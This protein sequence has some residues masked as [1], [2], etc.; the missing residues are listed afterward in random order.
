M[1]RA[2]LHALSCNLCHPVLF[3]PLPYNLAQILFSKNNSPYSSHS[4]CS[5]NC[6]HG[7]PYWGT[8]M[9]LTFLFFIRKFSEMSFQLHL[10]NSVHQTI[11]TLQGSVQ[12]SLHPQSLHNTPFEN[13]IFIH[14]SILTSTHY[15][16]IS[17]SFFFIDVSIYIHTY[18]YVLSMIP[19][20]ISY[21]LTNSN[22]SINIWWVDNS[23]RLFIMNSYT[24]VWF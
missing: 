19:S 22:C 16:H 17:I 1:N 4:L 3:L 5:S 12:I 7:V 11:S 14:Y 20:L 15:T 13:T 21:C 10:P 23:H 9:W 18:I 6:L 8:W 2:F 24:I